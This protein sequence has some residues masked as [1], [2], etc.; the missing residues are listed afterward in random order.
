MIPY[1]PIE[2]QGHGCP[3]IAKMADFIVS[4]LHCYACN[5][6]TNGELWY[7]K[8]ISKFCQDELYSFG[9]T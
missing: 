2:G 3:T 5:Q 8:T 1:D 9:T 7:S 6:K 4:L